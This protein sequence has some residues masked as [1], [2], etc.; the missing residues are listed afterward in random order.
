MQKKF[1]SNDN[2]THVYIVKFSKSG[3]GLRQVSIFF[4]P[5]TLT[6]SSFEAHEL[7]GF[8]L[9]H[10]KA[11]MK[12]QKQAKIGYSYRLMKHFVWAEKI[13]LCSFLKAF[14]NYTEFI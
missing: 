3:F 10:L 2:Q 8:N 4:G 7:K 1:L 11:L 12:D 9:S 5:Q 13:L 6:S 14:K